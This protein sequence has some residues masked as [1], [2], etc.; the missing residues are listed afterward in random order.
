LVDELLPRFWL[1]SFLGDDLGVLGC[2]LGLR[3]GVWVA[4]LTGL[5]DLSG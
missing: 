4:E 2:E 5:L 1:G 3:D